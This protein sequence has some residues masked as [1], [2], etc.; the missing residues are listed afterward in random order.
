MVSPQM[1][2][3]TARDFMDSYSLS[4][5]HACQLA[6]L[7]R[8]V[9]RYLSKRDDSEL[10]AKIIDI[11]Q[12]RRRFG[13]RRIHAL[14]QRDGQKVNHKRV[15]R[16]YKEAKLSLKK[17]RVGRK[18]ATGSR[19]VI[20]NPNAI[21]ERWSM[22]FVADKLSDGRRI[23]VLTIEDNY[24]RLALGTI[25]DNSIGGMRVVRELEQIMKE[26]GKPK[27]IIS[28]NGTEFTSNTVI[29]WS[30]EQGISWH[31]ITPGKPNENPFIESFNGRLRDECLN[32]NQFSS[33][34][35]AK[36]VINNWREDYN[37][38]RPHSA[39]GYLTPREFENGYAG[40]PVKQ[41]ALA[42]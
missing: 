10:K 31:Y 41:L 21:N 11:A 3:E 30:M 39:L 22:D 8:S 9:G 32:E 5:R 36:G 19:S 16:L 28:D 24:S 26:R 12:L 34:S 15:Y 38:Q 18:K 6:G 7:S 17:R 14:L 4:E 25:T 37:N 20:E 27:M 40:L 33:L 1:K 23:R 13:Y 42:K 35:E 2:R 29:K